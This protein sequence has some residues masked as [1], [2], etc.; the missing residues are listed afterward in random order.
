MDSETQ[1]LQ[2]AALAGVEL[3]REAGLYLATA[4]PFDDLLFLANEIRQSKMGDVVALCAIVNARSGSCSEDCAFC[5]QS[6]HHRTDVPTYPMKPIE[7]LVAAAKK[8]EAAG[9]DAFCIVT[10]G[11]GPEG[12]DF[13]ELLDRVRAVKAAIRSDARTRSEVLMLLGEKETR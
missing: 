3:G 9:A 7:E 5:A 12:D 1:R 10:S 4:A 11:R 2:Q 8:A 13:D 6:G